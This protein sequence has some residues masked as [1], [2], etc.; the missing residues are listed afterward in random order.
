MSEM[1]WEGL[2]EEDLDQINDYGSLDLESLIDEELSGLTYSL[3]ENP[4][5]TVSMTAQGMYCYHLPDQSS[6]VISIP[7]GMVTSGAVSFV[8][9]EGQSVL[10]VY[11][12]NEAVYMDEYTFTEPGVYRMLMLST[13]GMNNTSDMVCYQTEITFQIIMPFTSDL[14][15]LV[16]PKEFLLTG[17]TCN[18]RALGQASS[19]PLSQDGQYMCTW[20]AR[21]D[22]SIRYQA[23]F[24]VDT[25][26]PELIFSKDITQEPVRPPLV[27]EATEENCTLTVTH[28]AERVVLEDWELTQGGIYRLTVTDP[29]G[30]ARSYDVAMNWS[31]DIY[32][33]YLFII[34]VFLLAGVGIWLG[35]LRKHM[36]VL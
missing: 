22:S 19:L 27:M 21:G 5:M 32:L 15:T 17:I 3:I 20:A 29:A 30:N 1:L 2:S 26:A 16:T 11:R 8:P 7:A 10:S 9:G 23:A 12:G 13:D 35:F 4:D 28:G 14:E 33:T 6:F 25:Q 18:G 34:L 36:Q 31:A 24:T